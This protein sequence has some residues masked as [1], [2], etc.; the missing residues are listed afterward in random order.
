MYGK[1]SHKDGKG[2]G[3]EIFLME[4]GWGLRYS[5]LNRLVVISMYECMCVGIDTNGIKPQQ[6][7]LGFSLNKKLFN[8]SLV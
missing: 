1:F 8:S 5:A 7:W 4:R 2:K 3:R 6:P